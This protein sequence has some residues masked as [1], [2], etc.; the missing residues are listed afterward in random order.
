ME[1]AMT[2]SDSPR[3]RPSTL[4]FTRTMAAPLRQ[5]FPVDADDSADELT[6]LLEMADR[7]RARHDD[8]HSN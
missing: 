4:R 8:Q 1:N 5:E 7:R 6:E 2:Q 3:Q